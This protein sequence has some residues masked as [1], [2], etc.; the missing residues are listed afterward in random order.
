MEATTKEELSD[1]VNKWEIVSKS[2]INKNTR[3][4]SISVF[5]PEKVG[6]STFSKG[7]IVYTV[8]TE[9][10]GY[11]VRRRFKEFKLLR[12]CLTRTYSGLFIPALPNEPILSTN[13]LSGNGTDVDSDFIRNRTIQLN[14]FVSQISVIPFLL[15][16]GILKSF[17]SLQDDFMNVDISVC[18]PNA[19]EGEQTWKLLIDSYI[20]PLDAD[21]ILSD[22]KR[23]IKSLHNSLAALEVECLNLSRAASTY[24][25]QLRVTREKLQSWYEAEKD[26]QDPTKNEVP[27]TH[28]ALASHL[29]ALDESFAY[30]T[31]TAQSM[32]KIITWVLIANVQFQLVQL[33][34]FRSYLRHRE[35]LAQQLQQLERERAQQQQSEV[36]RDQTIQKNGFMETLSSFSIQSLQT[37]FS[38][39]GPES[40]SLNSF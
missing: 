20:L 9:P 12:D 25:R 21:R 28:P 24:S 19:S 1:W 13:I 8:R 16:S 2:I 3:Y 35:S 10:Y 22:I 31:S 15:T 7:H 39:T 23:Q 4:T 14:F 6:E 5:N 27:N 29:S 18:E 17:L 33:E 38:S 30:W 37:M 34:G 40:V 26:I 36:G 32:P 11:V